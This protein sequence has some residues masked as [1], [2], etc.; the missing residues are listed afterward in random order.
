MNAAERRG[1]WKRRQKRYLADRVA[2][3]NDLYLEE[4]LR[5][6]DRVYT[7]WT[8]EAEAGGSLTHPRDA[9]LPSSRWARSVG[10]DNKPG[11]YA[12]ESVGKYLK[13]NL[14]K[15]NWA[16][17]GNIIFGREDNESLTYLEWV[18][19]Y[20][21]VGFLKY[22]INMDFDDSRTTWTSKRGRPLCDCTPWF[23]TR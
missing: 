18:T 23:K 10:F 15:E 4:S 5:D 13:K 7:A 14:S 21:D 3:L 1:V 2:R 11:Y 22:C 6:S 12:L 19:G 9:Q 16:K 20:G 17:M 8:K